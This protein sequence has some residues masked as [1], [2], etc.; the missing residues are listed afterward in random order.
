[1]R[2]ENGQ[3]NGNLSYA[4]VLAL[5]GKSFSFFGLGGG[6]KTWKSTCRDLQCSC[7]LFVFWFNMELRCF[8]AIMGMYRLSSKFA[9]SMCIYI[10]IYVYI[11]VYA[12]PQ[13]YPP[14]EHTVNSGFLQ[15]S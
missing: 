3:L 12:P 13:N 4:G 9:G 5:L 11:H 10:Y 14:A 6:C 7:G 2:K 8:P 1:M 15:H